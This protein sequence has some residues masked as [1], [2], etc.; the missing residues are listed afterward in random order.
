MHTSEQLL[1]HR[2]GLTIHQSPLRYK[3][4]RLMADYPTPEPLTE[5]EWQKASTRL[6][7]WMSAK[8]T[9]ED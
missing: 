7:R 5:E 2:L 8:N 6:L 1:G 4:K 3:I 9:D